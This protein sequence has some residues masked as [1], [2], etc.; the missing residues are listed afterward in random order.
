M[1]KGLRLPRKTNIKKIAE[2][3]MDSTPLIKDIEINIEDKAEGETDITSK[4][5]RGQR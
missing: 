3:S 2:D 5:R 1:R 4:K